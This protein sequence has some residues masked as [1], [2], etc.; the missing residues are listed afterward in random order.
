[1]DQR[2]SPP[3]FDPLAVRDALDALW[4]RHGENR[5]EMRAELLDLLKDLVRNAHEAAKAGLEADGS[6]RR[7]ARALSIFQ[8]ELIRLIYDFITAHIYVVENPTESERMS[9]L[10][11]GGYGRGLMAPHSDVDLL[12]LLPY[13]Q[14]PWG[15]SIAEYMLYLMWDL[16]FKVGHATRSV[17][18]TVR[19]AKTDMTTRTALLDARFILGDEA[20][21]QRYQTQFREQVLASGQRDFITAKLEERIKRHERAGASRYKV[22][23]NIKDGK[24]GL[25][26]LHT[27]YWIAKYLHP[28]LN[29]EDFVEQGVFTRSE[30]VMYRRCED[31]LWTV[32]CN[33]HFLAGKPEER[34]TFDLQLAMAK[35][36]H[37]RERPGLMAVERFMKHYFLIAKDVGDLTRV[38]CSGLEVQ[39]LKVLPQLNKFLRPHTWR[40]RA[41]LAAISDFRIVNGRI[42]AKD[43]HVF[44]NDPVNLIR[45]FHFADKY[46]FEFHPEA[47]RLVRHSL[48][49]I[50]DRLRT[51]AEANRLFM[52]ILTSRSQ[53]EIALR[54]MNEAGVL[55]RF[56]PDFGRVVSMM[57]F[58]MYHHFTVDEH[59]IQ[60]VGVLS[61]IEKGELGDEL[62]LSTGI[63]KDI[64]NRRALYI[65][66]FLHDA[67]KGREEDHSIAGGRVTREVGRRLGLTPAGTAVAAWLVEHHLVMSQFAQSRDLNDAK[68]IRDFAD[69]VQSREL[70]MLLVILTAADI[71]AVG[72][73]VWTGWKGQLLRALYAE[74]EPIL[75]GG[76]TSTP[77]ETRVRDAVEAFRAA[78][79]EN[80]VAVE[81]VDAFVA[82]QAPSYWLR[83][84]LTRQVAHANLVSRALNERR[85]FAYEVR[86]EAFTSHT[87]LMLWTADRP[88]FAATMAGACAAAGAN[89]VGA[90]ITTTRDGMALNS[91]FLQRTFDDEREELDFA[92]RIGQTMEAA[93]RGERDVAKLLAKRER[94]QPRLDAFTVEPRVTIDNSLSDELTVIEVNARDRTGLL[95]DITHALADLH[96]DISSAHIATFG[97]KVVDVFYVTDRT[98]RKIVRESLRRRMREKVLAAVSAGDARGRKASRG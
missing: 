94:P 42:T 46:N 75:T 47:I 25:R 71:R 18:Q 88:G 90:H 24:G 58:N 28:D 7:C 2:L 48:H 21:W 26:D 63:I 56:I 52:E 62:P 84:D 3:F 96:V 55:G 79:A 11:T 68:T 92:E 67:A 54:R 97:E 74:T 22:E 50:D 64:E 89:I 8:D 23:P 51:N 1:M 49:F 83:T 69:M 15:E 6:G 38:L 77:R 57:Q 61:A 36:L 80:A 5:P 31:F 9:I 78:M 27:L 87:E 19:F 53:P 95:Y 39:Q 13:R 37:Y 72:P 66:A 33:L 60:T 14:T 10:A 98:H 40:T 29:G 17:D 16:G 81:E 85:G 20:L 30:Y 82:R 91:V 34:L 32:R 76:H 43:R 70:L 73:G 45:M 4:N 41:R 86:T 65:A 59:L 44:R 12:F 93:L 35:R